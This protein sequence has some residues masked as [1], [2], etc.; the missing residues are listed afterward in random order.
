VVESLGTLKSFGSFATKILSVTRAKEGS[1]PTVGSV[2][3]P[4]MHPTCENI[5]QTSRQLGLISAQNN[6]NEEAKGKRSSPRYRS[7]TR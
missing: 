4:L 3:K 6:I 7:I 1:E 2:T 5:E